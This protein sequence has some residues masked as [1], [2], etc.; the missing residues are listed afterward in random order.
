MDRVPV[1]VERASQVPRLASCGGFVRVVCHLLS[2]DGLH[3]W[4]QHLSDGVGDQRPLV[5]QAEQRGHI[6]RVDRHEA[7]LQSV[8]RSEVQPPG[9]AFLQLGTRRLVGKAA[10]QFF[11]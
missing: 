7:T 11:L 10:F 6:G 9:A 5:G 2:V 8:E 1:C 3:V 4:E